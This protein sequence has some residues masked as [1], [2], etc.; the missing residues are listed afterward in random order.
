[1]LIQLPAALHPLQLDGCP[2]QVA[3][4]GRGTDVT[5]FCLVFSPIRDGLKSN[6]SVVL[7]ASSSPKRKPIPNPVHCPKTLSS[8]MPLA[9]RSSQTL[10]RIDWCFTAS[11]QMKHRATGVTAQP[12]EAWHDV[13]V[14][15]FAGLCLSGDQTKRKTGR[16]VCDT[17]LGK[18]KCPRERKRPDIA[19]FRVLPTCP[20][21]HHHSLLQSNNIG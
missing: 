5:S 19:P 9:A 11:H 6:A 16:S 2:P 4:G 18:V 20:P 3:L 17:L 10:I 14:Q 12:G 15:V 13:E 7:N 21:S 1:M 8:R